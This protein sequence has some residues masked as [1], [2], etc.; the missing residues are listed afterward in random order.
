MWDNLDLDQRS[1]E[2]TDE[3]TD[4]GT[5]ADGARGTVT[6][7]MMMEVEIVTDS[8]IIMEIGI[9]EA[10]TENLAKAVTE[11]CPAQR[12]GALI[13][14]LGHSLSVLTKLGTPAQG[15]AV[16]LDLQV[17]AF[18]QTTGQLNTPT[19]Q[20]RPGKY[21]QLV[22]IPTRAASTQSR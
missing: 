22:P 7:I 8:A 19:A 21:S 14:P 10:G 11:R 13:A 15:P 3:K 12:H 2:S 20:H 16:A 18:I 17:P 1:F 6:I 4:I 9:P 5:K